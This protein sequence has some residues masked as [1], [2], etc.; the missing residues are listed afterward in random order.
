MS[1]AA[2]VSLVQIK[3]VPTKKLT[4]THANQRGG[5]R[6]F[7]CLLFTLALTFP[8][9]ILSIVPPLRFWELWREEAREPPSRS[10]SVCLALRRC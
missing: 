7:K 1:P 9:E 10:E 2:T 3:F 4:K 6:L 5:L 8:P